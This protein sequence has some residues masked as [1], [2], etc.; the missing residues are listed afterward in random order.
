MS[1]PPEVILNQASTDWD[2]GKLMEALKLL[3]SLQRV[4]PHLPELNYQLARCYN[5]IGRHEEALSHLGRELEIQPNHE[6]AKTLADFLSNAL[7]PPQIPEDLTREQSWYSSV[8]RDFL[9]SLQNRLH[10][11]SYMGV[12]ILKNP[13][14]LAIY[15]QLLWTLKPRT[16]VEIGSKSGG[17]ALWFAHQ[18]DAFRSECRIFSIDLIKVE[19]VSHPRIAFLEGDANDLG[20]SEG[21]DWAAD[22]EP[23]LLVI[24]DANHEA[25]TCIRIA[26]FIHPLLRSGDYFVVEDG[27]ISD[28]YLEGYPNASSGP[29]LAIRHLL[30]RHADA[31]II[32]RVY[33]DMFGYNATWCTN[34]F[35]KRL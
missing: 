6:L 12:P 31:Y 9:R 11:F 7:A 22:L 8:P 24:D 30:E 32:D 29:H 26:D 17:S 10:N 3:R 4:H 1:I 18:L 16:I 34:G 21:I 13:F 25:S 5:Q 35:L 20:R 14:D 19:N 28:L 15:S 33:C 27:I 2:E 23:P